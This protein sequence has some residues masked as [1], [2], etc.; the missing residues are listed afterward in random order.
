VPP[1]GFGVAYRNG[2]VVEV[3]PMGALLRKLA[4]QRA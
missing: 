4:A 3:G 1:A 2:A